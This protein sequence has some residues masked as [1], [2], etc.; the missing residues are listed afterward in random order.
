MAGFLE[1]SPW[2]DAP[3]VL[4]ALRRTG[5]RLVLL[6]NFTQAMLHSAVSSAGLQRLFE[7][8]LSTDRVRA[9]KPDPRAYRMAIDALRL[10]RAA[11]LFAAFAGWD[12]AGAKAFGF[13]TFWL[14]RMASPIEELGSVPDG[15]GANLNDLIRFVSQGRPNDA[16]TGPRLCM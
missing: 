16:L 6:S 7:P 1:L 4:D 13:P 3:A 14:N 15:V 5:I 12:A 11:I 8:H 9:Y 10:R 2:P